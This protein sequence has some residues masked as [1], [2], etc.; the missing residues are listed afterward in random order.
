MKAE[1]SVER[2]GALVQIAIGHASVRM[3]PVEAESFVLAVE[4]VIQQA[5]APAPIVRVH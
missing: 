4:R 2:I 3:S 1:L 5:Q